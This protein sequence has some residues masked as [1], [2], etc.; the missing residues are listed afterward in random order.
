MIQG[1]KEKDQEMEDFGVYE[2]FAKAFETAPEKTEAVTDD[3]EGA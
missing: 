3:A 1:Q 2:N